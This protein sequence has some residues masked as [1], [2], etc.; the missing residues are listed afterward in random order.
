MTRFG[1]GLK[2]V[3]FEAVLTCIN[4]AT[5]LMYDYNNMTDRLKANHDACRLKR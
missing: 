5:C 1:V 4:D 2:C 3:D